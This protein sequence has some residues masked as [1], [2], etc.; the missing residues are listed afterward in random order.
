MSSPRKKIRG[1]ELPVHSLN[2]LSGTQEQHFSH[3]VFGVTFWKVGFTFGVAAGGVVPLAGKARVLAMSSLATVLALLSKLLVVVAVA[4]AT[5]QYLVA[6]LA[7][8][9]SWTTF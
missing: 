5:E 2:S 1:E 9:T 8:V 4:I 6:P 3:V 7:L